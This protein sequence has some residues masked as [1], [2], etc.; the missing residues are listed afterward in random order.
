MNKTFLKLVD[1]KKPIFDSD[2]NKK[3]V[4]IKIVGQRAICIRNCRKHNYLWLE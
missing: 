2:Q 1:K 3:Y 4:F